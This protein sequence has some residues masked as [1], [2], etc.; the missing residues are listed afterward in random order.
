MAGDTP[1]IV[2]E[3]ERFVGRVFADLLSI[4]ADR[5]EVAR[6]RLAPEVRGL[7]TEALFRFLFEISGLFEFKKYTK[8]ER[9]TELNWPSILIRAYQI[10]SEWPEMLL[11][12]LEE[13]RLDGSERAGRYGIRKEFGDLGALLR[14]W[15]AVAE[16]MAVVLPVIRR[17]LNLHPEIALKA[18]SRIAE[19]ILPENRYANLTE[20]RQRYRWSHRKAAKLLQIPGVVVGSADGS[21]APL[22]IDRQKVAA[23]HDDLATMISRRTIRAIWGL[24]HDAI[25]Q[26]ADAGI[27]APVTEPHTALVGNVDGLFRR[28]Q[29]AEVIERAH[30]C[31]SVDDYE[32]NSV[33][34][35]RVVAELGQE[36]Q[37]PWPAVLEAVLARKLKPVKIS[38][39]TKGGFRR[40][41][42]RKEDAYRWISAETG[43]GE[44]TRSLSEVA[45]RL[46]MHMDVVTLLIEKGLLKTIK[47]RAG[48]RGRRVSIASLLAFESEYVSS[49]SLAAKFKA[50]SNF[51]IDS[52]DLLGV[53]PV[54]ELPTIRRVYRWRDIPKDFRILSRSEIAEKRKALG[55]PTK[56]HPWCWYPTRRA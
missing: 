18:K 10:A 47:P 42:F 23:I 15:D 34:F 2:G 6:S 19:A 36:V 43:Q 11:E 1:S 32:G 22:Q 31:E 28:H 52:L 12:M 9:P 44:G 51:M 8:R 27:F 30:A 13:T 4:D 29:V 3:D 38:Q 39:K 35:D 45:K 5:R 40:I 25:V 17:Y 16:I 26:L 50:R 54:P 21:G 46:Q 53:K 48:E 14:D 24:H 41:R 37:K 33:S 7:P 49:A 20:I 56:A 55:L